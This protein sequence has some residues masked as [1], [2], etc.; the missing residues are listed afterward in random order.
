MSTSQFTIY[1][2][3][4]PYGPGPL[5]GMSGSLIRVLN[6]C[7]V[8]GYGT[9]ST[10]KPAAGWSKPLPDES[11]GY[12]TPVLGCYKQGSGSMMTLFVNDSGP[13]QSAFG[14]EA[15][16]TGWE[17]M[18]SLTGSGLGGKFT[19]SN[20]AGFGSNQ[21]PQ[22][23]QLLTYGHVVCRKS[24]AIDSNARNWTIAADASTMYL[25]IES[26]DGVS[27]DCYNVGF[28]DCYSLRGSADV[29]RC[30]IYGKY[31]EN[32]GTFGYSTDQSAVM[33]PSFYFCIQ[34][35]N[36]GH[37]LARSAFGGGA[38]IPFC[39]KGDSTLSTTGYTNPPYSVGIHG[40]LSTPNVDGGYYMS[41]LELAEANVTNPFIRGRFRGMYH[42]GH[43]MTSF[44]NGQIISGS[45][46]YS[47]KVFAIV[48]Q[49]DGT[50]LKS[51]WA[52]EISPTVETN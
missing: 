46:N 7:L 19:G 39:R 16:L 40:C 10:Y 50:T 21:F 29:W 45:G 17:S 13:N 31:A 14:K 41:P 52:L 11:G 5:N 6:A 34:G 22:P 38:S 32:D 26:Q 1:S 4:D 12:L 8:N 15:W 35:N 43:P 28:G 3:G 20:S 30:F 2:A 37:F 9:G 25:W 48:K 23:S 44:S 33:A 36:N 18:T 51:F 49:Y 27:G 24:S 47:G 42:V